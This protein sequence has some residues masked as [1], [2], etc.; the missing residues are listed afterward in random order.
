M[1]SLLIKFQ[2]GQ[3]IVETLFTTDIMH[4]IVS[5]IKIKIK[6]HIVSSYH[7]E[8]YTLIDLNLIFLLR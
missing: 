5:K 3:Q 8:F 7:L 6:R 2:N 1:W 4:I